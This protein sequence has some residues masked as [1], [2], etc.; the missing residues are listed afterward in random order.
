MISLKFNRINI[1]YYFIDRLFT[2][3]EMQKILV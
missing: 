3:P 2:S 1:N